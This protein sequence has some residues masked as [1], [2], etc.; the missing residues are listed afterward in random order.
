[1]N[2]LIAGSITWAEVPSD[3]DILEL[4][5]WRAYAKV[6]QYAKSAYHHTVRSRKPVQRVTPPKNPQPPIGRKPYLVMKQEQT[7]HIVSQGRLTPVREVVDMVVQSPVEYDELDNEFV[8]PKPV[9]MPQ[10]KPI[11]VPHVLPV[12]VQWKM[13]TEDILS[14][15]ESSDESSDESSYTSSYLMKRPSKSR[16]R[17]NKKVPTPIVYQPSF[18][19]LY[20]LPIIPYLYVILFLII[21]GTMKL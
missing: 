10:I 8:S 20:V 7:K 5:G 6:Q 9:E 16:L 3:D 19:Q 18:T 13:P 21:I 12:E 2:Q 4:E 17:K 14:S 11:E 15:G 1:M